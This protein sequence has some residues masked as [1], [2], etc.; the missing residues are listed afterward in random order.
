MATG[1][2]AWMEDELAGDQFAGVRLGRC[3]STLLD[4]LAGAMG[5]SISL[6]CQDWANTKAAA[7][8]SEPG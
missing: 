8:K 3:L 5:D 4:Q 7:F 1:T 6:A 2:N